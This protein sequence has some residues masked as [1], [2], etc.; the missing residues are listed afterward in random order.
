MLLRFNRDFSDRYIQD[1]ERH[2]TFEPIDFKTAKNLLEQQ[3]KLK[4]SSAKGQKEQLIKILNRNTEDPLY[5]MDYRVGDNTVIMRL[6]AWGPNVE[7]I[8]PWSLRQR[9]KEDMEQTWR[10][11]ESDR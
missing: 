4:P 6:R 2:A 8:Y 9:M 3:S 5:Q 10:L 11:Y 7:V 1:T